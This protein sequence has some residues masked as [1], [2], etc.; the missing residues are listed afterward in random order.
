[1]IYL[2]TS[3][4]IFSFSENEPLPY[5]PNFLPN[6]YLG[7][8]IRYGDEMRIILK[9]RMCTFT[10]ARLGTSI[11]DFSFFGERALPDLPKLLRSGYL[12]LGTRHGG[13]RRIILK[14]KTCTFT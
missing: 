13:E 14:L 6:G 3:I 2:G 12:G 11:N 10:W 7:V 8:R 4:K 5:R 1:M 9:L